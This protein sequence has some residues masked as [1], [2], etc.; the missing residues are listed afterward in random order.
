MRG[1]G[2]THSIVWRRLD[3]PGH[4][5]ATLTRTSDGWRID[6][7]A[8]WVEEGLPC[9]LVY[10]VACDAAWRTVGATVTGAIGRGAIDATITVDAAQRWRLN[11][12]PHPAVDNCIDVDLS[13]TPATNLLPIR[14]LALAPGQQADAPAAWLRL[15]PA[16]PNQPTLDP[17]HQTY[18]RVDE[19]T[20]RYHADD[21]SFSAELKVNVV[22][23][24][25]AYPPLWQAVSEREAPA[26]E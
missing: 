10:R 12:E 11:G 22:G 7:A 13:F 8:V 20:W 21:L 14:R 9:R 15:T 1:M 26:R 16:A 4:D 5:A 3:R 19:T 25:T 24:V 18:R 6:G 17:L 23:F 2:E